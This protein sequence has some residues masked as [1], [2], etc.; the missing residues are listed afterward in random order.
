MNEQS[1]LK[2]SFGARRN[3]GNCEHQEASAEVTCVGTEAD[4]GEKVTAMLA[5]LRRRVY[6]ALSDTPADTG[7]EKEPAK[8]R[9]RPKKEAEPAEVPVEVPVE[10]DAQVVANLR[11]AAS[12]AV[13]RTSAMHVIEYL[14]TTFGVGKV[15][16]LAPEDRA[17]ALKGLRELDVE[18]DVPAEDP[19][20][21]DVLGD[22]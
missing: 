12:E 6:A 2:V 19:L 20:V 11:T 5:D 16:Q 8:K 18:K 4:A 17:A 21:D 13:G 14:Q 1:T 15:A 3:S 22:L 10:D 7:A 9:G